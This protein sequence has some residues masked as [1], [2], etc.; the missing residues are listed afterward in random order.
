MTLENKNAIIYGAGGSMGGAVAKALAAN[1][2]KVFLTGRNLS[3]VQK[4]ADEI[5]ASGGRAEVGRA[6][7][8]DAKAINHFLET[9]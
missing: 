7:A 4:V 2:A 3:S 6:D 1:G 9:M 8:L 5:L